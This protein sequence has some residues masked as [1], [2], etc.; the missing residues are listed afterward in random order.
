MDRHDAHERRDGT[1]AHILHADL[2]LPETGTGD[3][4]H[5][6]VG[7]RDKDPREE[8]LLDIDLAAGSGVSGP[9]Q[10]GRQDIGTGKDGN[11]LQYLLD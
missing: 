6:H 5:P 3:G 10:S 8:C 11:R 2:Y 9:G 4:E 1:A 7:V